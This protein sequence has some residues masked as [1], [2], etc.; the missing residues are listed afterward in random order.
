MRFI[1]AFISLAFVSCVSPKL[2][3]RKPVPPP[4]SDQIGSQPW[5]IPQ[6]G[7]GAGAMGGLLEGR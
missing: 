5:N 6:R 7:E 1:L 4:G 3:E 2:T